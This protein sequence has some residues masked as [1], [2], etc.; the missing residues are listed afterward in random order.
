[1]HA[2]LTTSYLYNV[3]F[4]AAPPPPPDTDTYWWRKNTKKYTHD[5][6]MTDVLPLCEAEGSKNFGGGGEKR[7]QEDIKIKSATKRHWTE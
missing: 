2:L 7:E 4:Y 5:T 1:M 6:A 3:W